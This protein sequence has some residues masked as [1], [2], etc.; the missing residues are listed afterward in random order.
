[1]PASVLIMADR[2]D[3][4]TLIGRALAAIG[5]RT[6]IANDLRHGGLILARETPAVAVIDLAIPGHYDAAVHWLRRDPTRAGMSLVRVSAL[7]RSG[8]VPRS[9]VRP[10]MLVPKP[11]TPRQIVDAV[12]TVLARRAMRQRVPAAAL[13][14]RP[15]AATPG[16][17]PRALA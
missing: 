9:E 12:R 3:I 8:G 17:G 5:V 10:D 4:A 6:V 15:P 16:L 1:M 7:V 2:P 11:F 13:A 14:P